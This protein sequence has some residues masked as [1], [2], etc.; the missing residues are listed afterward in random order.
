MS[1]DSAGPEQLSTQPAG[2]K[3]G[4]R[5]EE[6]CGVSLS[7]I[8]KHFEKPGRC[9][10]RPLITHSNVTCSNKKQLERK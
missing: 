10:C 5:E 6:Q 8:R 1:D 9:L 2:K 4:Q 3:I 7:L